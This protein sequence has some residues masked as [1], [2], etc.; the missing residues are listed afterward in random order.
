LPRLR[1]SVRRHVRELD[2]T[3]PLAPTLP[4]IVG[5]LAMSGRAAELIDPPGLRNAFTCGGVELRDGR[6]DSSRAVPNV[7]SNEVASP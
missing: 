2:D 5:V 6:A 3:I 1:K 4:D 7:G